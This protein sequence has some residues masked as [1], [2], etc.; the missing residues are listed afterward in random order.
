MTVQVAVPVAGGNVLTFI[1][2]PWRELIIS[3]AAV[4]S[5]PNAGIQR[6][7]IAANG[8]GWTQTR[9]VASCLF[10][11]DGTNGALLL[12]NNVRAADEI[13]GAV[14]LLQETAGDA[15]YQRVGYAL[16]SAPTQDFGPIYLQVE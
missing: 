15:D 10:D 5:A 8:F 12:G 1:K 3:P 7:L 16:S 13:A 11:T 2:N 6:V 9:G 14:G 4:N